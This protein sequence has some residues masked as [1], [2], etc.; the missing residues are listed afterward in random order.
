MPKF[1]ANISTL[2]QEIPFLE[3]FDAAKEAGF[4]AV[5]CQFPYGTPEQAIADKLAETG[6]QMVLINLPPGNWEAG[7]RGLAALPGRETDFLDSLRLGLDYAKALNCPKVHCMAGIVPAGADTHDYWQT[8][9]GNLAF[10]IEAFNNAGCMLLIEPINAHDMPGYLMNSLEKGRQAMTQTGS[11]IRLQFDAYHVQMTEGDVAGN[12]DRLKGGIGHIQ[13]AN[14]PGRNEPDR[15]GDIDYQAFFKQLDDAGYD[16]WVGCEYRPETTTL[17]G[18]D[19][20][21]AF[22][23]KP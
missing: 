18:L 10:A 4:K 15:A 22:G 13:I 1:A 19:W 8:Y 9:L 12:Y 5:E 3:R 2:F 21:D 17:E 6:L 11:G 23:L 20:F 14:V 16:G 7:D